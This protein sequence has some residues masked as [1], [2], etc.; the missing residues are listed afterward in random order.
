MK[1]K[2]LFHLF[3]PFTKLIQILSFNKTILNFFNLKSLYVIFH[4]S[5]PVV[6]NND[7]RDKSKFILGPNVNQQSYL[8]RQLD[9]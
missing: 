3:V 8:P 1:N 2:T 7:E 9:L 5:N 4:Y 6:M